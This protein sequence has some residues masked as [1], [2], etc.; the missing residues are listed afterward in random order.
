MLLRRSRRLLASPPGPARAFLDSMC[1][2][3]RASAS[4]A[5][6]ARRSDPAKASASALARGAFRIVASAV[7]GYQLSRGGAATSASRV[8]SASSAS[9]CARSCSEPV[10]VVGWSF[11]H[12]RSTSRTCRKPTAPT[13]MST[14]LSPDRRTCRDWFDD[15]GDAVRA[16]TRSRG[17]DDARGKGGDAAVWTFRWRKDGRRD[18]AP[19]RI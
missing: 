2:R 10:A 17:V 19:R 7:C 3:V 16:R 12:G 6:A 11:L 15:G 8:V 14:P 13:V 4:A 5:W 18:D 9:A 1:D